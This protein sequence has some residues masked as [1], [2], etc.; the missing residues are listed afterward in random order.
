[1]NSR[2]IRLTHLLDRLLNS[3]LAEKP[4]DFYRDFEEV[5]LQ[6]ATEQTA[7]LKE[8]IRKGGK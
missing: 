4:S 2:T 6:K 3:A 8:E 5:M 1:M 7:A